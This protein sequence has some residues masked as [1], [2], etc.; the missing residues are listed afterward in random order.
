MQEL[1]TGLMGADGE[2]IVIYDA[3]SFQYTAEALDSAFIV[4]CK[5][6]ACLNPSP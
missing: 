4:F 3:R 6:P 1:T 2:D 5:D